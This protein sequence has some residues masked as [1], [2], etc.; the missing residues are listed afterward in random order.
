LFVGLLDNADFETHYQGVIFTLKIKFAQTITLG[1]TIGNTFSRVLEPMLIEPLRVVCPQV[2]SLFTINCV[3]ALRNIINGF[4][5][6]SN[7]AA[8]RSA[9]RLHGPYKESLKPFIAP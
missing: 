6:S 8:N 9:F 2:I 1:N 5:F 4:L 7:T 3:D